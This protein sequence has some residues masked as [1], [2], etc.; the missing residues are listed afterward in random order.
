[1]SVPALSKGEVRNRALI[2]SVEN[3]HP[4][5]GLAKR[6]GAGRDTK[7]LHRILSQRGFQV[8]ILNDPDAH[9]ILEAFEAECEASV[10]S[11]FVAVVSSHGEEGLIFGADGHPVKLADIY[12]LFR[13]A[14]MTSKPKL[15]LIQAC[16]GSKLD[17]GVQ[18]E[19]DSVDLSEEATIF[20]T[21]YI[22]P[23]T[24]V[25]YATP[26][27][28]SAFMHPTGSVFLQTFCDL[29]EDGTDWEISRLLTRLN[30]HVAH[31]FEARGNALRGKKEMPCFISRLT[32]EFYPFTNSIRV[33]QLLGSTHVSC[34]SSI[35]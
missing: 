14:T 15:F 24:V 23:E 10:G 32:S 1:M 4:G 29:V 21:L 2:V 26:P 28:Y 35:R 11:C 5:V 34:R 8:T 7:R 31:E 20:E 30:W 19:V 12:T 13:G 22:P 6:L 17:E 16:R 27:G 3:F 33:S 9:E 18:V 25:A